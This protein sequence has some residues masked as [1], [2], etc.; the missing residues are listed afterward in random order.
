MAKK[1]YTAEDI[2]LSKSI[3]TI[4]KNLSRLNKAD[5]VNLVIHFI[6]EDNESDKAV[7]EANASSWFLTA[8]IALE[9]IVIVFLVLHIKGLAF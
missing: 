3:T 8:M 4:K 7:E 5:L 1:K 6:E 9:A 2:D